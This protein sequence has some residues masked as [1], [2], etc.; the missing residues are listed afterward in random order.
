MRQSQEQVILIR[1]GY[2]Q[3]FENARRSADAAELVIDARSE[4][5]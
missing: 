4:G 5:R 2:A 1:L 3:I